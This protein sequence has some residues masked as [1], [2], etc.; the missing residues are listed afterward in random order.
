MNIS[1]IGNAFILSS[2]YTGSP[3]HMDEYILD[4]MTFI[5]AYRQLDL[6]VTFT[7]NPQWDEIK[8]SSNLR[9]KIGLLITLL[10]NLNAP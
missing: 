10:R 4:A 1:D 6:F 2:S 9:L 7:C 3:R 5:L 8:K